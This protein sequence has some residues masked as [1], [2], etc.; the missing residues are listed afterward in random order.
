[1]FSEIIMAATDKIQH[2]G[3]VTSLSAQ[4]LEVVI[5]SHSACA[6]C[7]AKS[8]CGMSDTKQKIITVQRPAGEIKVGDKVMVYASTG[9]AAYSV[10]LAYVMPSVLIITA[11]F[12]LEKTGGNELYSAV[13][14][15]ILLAFYF[16]TLYLCRN[17]ISKRIKFTI[18]KTGNY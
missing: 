2:E 16:F 9:N 10:V 12:F 18:E 5:S 14:S 8:A 7:H 1:M 3:I 4:T 13:I 15:L 11:V 17:K 6:A